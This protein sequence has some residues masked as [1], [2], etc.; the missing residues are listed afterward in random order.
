MAT[1]AITETHK[2][3]KA[4]PEPVKTILLTGG[5]SA[6]RQF[7]K[8]IKDHFAHENLEVTPMYGNQGPMSARSVLINQL[9]NR[10]CTDKVSRL[11]VA[12]GAVSEYYDSIQGSKFLL[13][14][15]YYILVDERYNRDRHPDCV[16]KFNKNGTASQR[17]DRD[18]NKVGRYFE[19]ELDPNLSAE[20]KRKELKE[21]NKTNPLI[22]PNRLHKVLSKDQVSEDLNPVRY[23]LFEP[24]VSDPKISASIVYSATDYVDGD[25]A[26]HDGYVLNTD[27]TLKPDIKPM[28]TV[29]ATLDPQA[30]AHHGGFAI[31]P[32]G[33]GVNRYEVNALVKFAYK[34]EATMSVRFELLPTTVNAAGKIVADDN[35]P[36]VVP[37]SCEIWRNTH[38][39]LWNQGD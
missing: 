27:E 34:T 21:E 7:Q 8:R 6:N 35:R 28:R 29:S 26:M 22:A 16:K 38:S 39:H 31:S 3:I 11:L 1:D 36:L 30:L 2:M 19:F 20:D 14:N 24:L 9:S 23:I 12:Q 4:S 32:D 5:F 18:P 25:C 15:N 17:R 10:R 37:V 33:N 13:K